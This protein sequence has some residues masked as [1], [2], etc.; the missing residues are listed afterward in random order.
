MFVK[1]LLFFQDLACF[2]RRNLQTTRWWSID[3]SAPLLTRMPNTDRKKSAVTVQKS[4]SDRW[5]N[6]SLHQVYL[7]KSVLE[8]IVFIMPSALLQHSCSRS[9]PMSIASAI[10][11]AMLANHHLPYHSIVPTCA[12]NSPK[13][14]RQLYPF[15][16]YQYFYELR[17]QC[18]WV[19]SVYLNQTQGAV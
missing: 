15:V 19:W 17:V 11:I 4:M 3:S 5:P 14:I 9:L 6:E 18:A 16:G 7:C 13:R 1:T 2:S 12:L 8:E 10:S